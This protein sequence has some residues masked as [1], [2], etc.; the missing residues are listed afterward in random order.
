MTKIMAEHLSGGAFVYIR[1][2]TADQLVHNQDSRRRC[3]LAECAGHLGWSLVDGIAYRSSAS[4]NRSCSG[5][6][7]GRR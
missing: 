1:Q 3:G 6:R 7:G 5:G 2:S 4:R